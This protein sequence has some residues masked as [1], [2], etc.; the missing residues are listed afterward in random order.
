MTK[1]P[2]ARVGGGGFL[3]ALLPLGDLVR[4]LRRNTAHHLPDFA[5]GPAF[6]VQI[7]RNLSAGVPHGGQD[8]CLRVG[9]ALEPL[10]GVLDG[11]DGVSEC[12][13]SGLQCRVHGLRVGGISVGIKNEVDA[14]LFKL[15]LD[16]SA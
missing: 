14:D 10:G 16:I 4:A 6:V 9:Q 2:A 15:Y 13:Y 7:V 5:P 11:G 12:G 1:A 3:R 8:G